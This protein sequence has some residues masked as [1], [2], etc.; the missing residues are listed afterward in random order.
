[1]VF[2]S[3]AVEE[4]LPPVLS[5]QLAVRGKSIAAHPNSGTSKCLAIIVLCLNLRDQDKQYNN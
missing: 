5:W 3:K 4:K 2:Q 1:M